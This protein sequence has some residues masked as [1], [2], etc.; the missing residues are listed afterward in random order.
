MEGPRQPLEREYANILN[1]LKQEL[2]PNTQWSVASE[3]PTAL[4]ISNIHNIRIITEDQKVLSHA[5]LK[6]L[7]VK[8]PQMMLKVAAI[9][10]VVTDSEHRNQGLSRQI[11]TDCLQEAERQECDIAVLW[12][13]L[14]EFYSK[15]GFELGGSEISF[16]FEQPFTVASKGLKILTS[17]QVSSE[18][19]LRL[20]NQHTV[21]SVR[22]SEDIRKFLQIPQS[23]I[24]TAWDQKNQLVAYAIEGKGA[25]LTNYI[26]EWGGAVSDLLELFS[27]IRKDKNIPFTVIS[28]RHSTNFD[29]KLSEIPGVVRN[30]GFLG[31][32]KITRPEILFQKI[33][34]LARNLGHIDFVLEKKDN[35]VHI[36]FGHDVIAI[37]DERD[38]VRIFFG[39]QTEIPYLKEQSTAKLNSFL[40]LPLWIWGWDSI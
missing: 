16:V 11:I 37:A 7:I 9:G 23:K 24:Y 2:R 32:I 22:S 18:A 5:V 29:R 15:F 12:T 34:R 38:L 40:P 1:F 33:K 6:P 13:H 36:G 19:I 39:P 28:P 26:H 4:S 30:E 21:N 10:S 35:E 27:F 17:A 8:T 31:M 14:Y 25:D 3:Y 20:F